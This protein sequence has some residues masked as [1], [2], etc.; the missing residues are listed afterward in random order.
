MLL[1]QNGGGHQ[2]RH[3]LATHYCLESRAQ[4]NLGLA[5]AHIPTKQPVH[6]AFGF[7]IGFDLLDGK[8]LIRG[9]DVRKRSF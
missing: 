9:F 6:R 5:V 1:R 2:N 3:L 4:G 8:Q 7:H